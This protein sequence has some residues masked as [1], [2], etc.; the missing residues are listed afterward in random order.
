M[1]GL[2]MDDLRG[3]M[4]LVQRSG[5]N[6]VKCFSMKKEVVYRRCYI[7]RY[8]DTLWK[9]LSHTAFLISKFP[10]FFLIAKP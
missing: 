10:G 9:S 7:D 1:I 2:C 6:C 5:K 3:L 8:V 4:F